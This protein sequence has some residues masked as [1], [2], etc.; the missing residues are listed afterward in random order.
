MAD[1]NT[2]ADNG[3]PDYVSAKQERYR[4]FIELGGL[5][6]IYE[7]LKAYR[8]KPVLADMVTDQHRDLV[9]DLRAGGMRQEKIAVV[10][11]ISKERLQLLFPLELETGVDT[12]EAAAAISLHMLGLAGDAAAN[13]SFLRH[14]PELRWGSK[15]QITGKD[16]APLIPEQA[17]QAEANQIFLASILTALSTDK[18]KFKKPIDKV[19]APKTVQ[20]DKVK[21]P[22]PTTLKRPKGD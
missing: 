10:L 14:H 7:R 21:L 11:G 20:S 17:S 18:A 1:D 3:E 15:S 5:E 4:R 19:K 16:D 22:K 6:T 13:V 12:A 8:R 9:L 2:A